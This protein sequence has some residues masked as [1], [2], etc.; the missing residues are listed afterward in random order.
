MCPSF[1]LHLHSLLFNCSMSVGS[2]WPHSV[3]ILHSAR[4]S[5]AS[6]LLCIQ[7]LVKIWSSAYFWQHIA[8]IGMSISLARCFTTLTGGH[9]SSFNAEC[10]NPGFGSVYALSHLSVSVRMSAEHLTLISSKLYRH[11]HTLMYSG[12]M[13]C[14]S[15]LATAP[16]CVRQ[17][18]LA[19]FL[20]EY[21]RKHVVVH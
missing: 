2:E 4:V 17:A 9:P 18:M 14:R 8:H 1:A 3:R 19:A 21:L 13:S 7:L 16:S 12:P 10:L 11:S 20:T 5:F 15:K 6:V